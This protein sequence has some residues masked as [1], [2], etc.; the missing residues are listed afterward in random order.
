M[1]PLVSLMDG[2]PLLILGQWLSRY[3]AGGLSQFWVG[4]DG[5]Q[6]VS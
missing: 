2:Q 6:Q 4:L 3:E 5:H 1:W